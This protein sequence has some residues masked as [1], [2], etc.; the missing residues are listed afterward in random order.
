MRWVERIDS[1]PIF[2]ELLPYIQ[3]ALI[4]IYVNTT[5]TAI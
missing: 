4:K 3:K 2:I 1:V 5:D